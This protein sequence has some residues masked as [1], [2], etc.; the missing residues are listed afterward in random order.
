MKISGNVSCLKCKEEFSKYVFNNHYKYRHLGVKKKWAG[1]GWN[2]GLTKD[3]D[4]RVKNS[5]KEW[6]RRYDN[7]EFVLGGK[8]LP[9]ETKIK[10]SNSMKLAHKEGR[11]WNIGKSRWNNKKSYPEEFFTQVILNEFED[12]NFIPEYSIGIYSLD[13]A[14]PHKKRGIEIN[15]DQH[16]RFDEYIERDR[17]KLDYLSASGWEI[18]IIDWKKM[19]K[20][21]K[22]WIHKAKTFIQ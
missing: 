1:D 22:T 13:F 21:T 2:K 15:G 20:D 18:L 16:Y 14:W 17:R 12:K 10:I 11:A 19:F 9:E 3:T 7:K 6:R 8:P 5:A 4:E